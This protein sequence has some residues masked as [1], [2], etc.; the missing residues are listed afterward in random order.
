MSTI[1]SDDRRSRSSFSA[2]ASKSRSASS[3]A[4]AWNRRSDD[5]AAVEVRLLNFST[6]TPCLANTWLTS[7]TMPIRS[8]PTRLNDIRREG[9]VS[10]EL[11]SLPASTVTRRSPSARNAPVS[12]SA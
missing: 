5:I 3:S 6:L 10:L 2:S 11:A 8:C 12:V 1:R 9:V 7:R 4:S